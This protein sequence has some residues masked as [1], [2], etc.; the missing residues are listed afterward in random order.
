MKISWGIQLWKNQ[1]STTPPFPNIDSN[2]CINAHSSTVNLIN[3]NWLINFHSHINDVKSFKF[4]G[5][6]ARVII[7]DYW[8]V[9][10]N[11]CLCICS[12]KKWRMVVPDIHASVKFCLFVYNKLVVPLL[13]IH[14]QQ[15]WI[16]C[17]SVSIS[18]IL[19]YML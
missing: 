16:S 10:L 18:H 9:G 7:Y 12:H 4:E 19:S 5:H 6:I 3:H 15:N 13:W 1:T 14:L 2:V 11:L 17:D 8:D